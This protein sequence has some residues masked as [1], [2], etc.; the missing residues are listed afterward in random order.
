MKK[1]PFFT[2]GIPVYNTEK[3]IGECLDSILSQDFDDFEIVCVDDGSTD[4]SLQILNEYSAKDTRVKVLSRKNDGPSTAR[5]AILYNASGKYILFADSD[6]KLNTNALS[7]AYRELTLN[8]Y[9]DIME[10]GFVNIINGVKSIYQPSYPGDEYFS[11]LLSDDERAVKLCVEKKYI[12]YVPAKFICTDFLSSN[13]ITFNSRYRIGEDCDFIFQ[14]HRKTKNIIFSH[15]LTSIHYS[16]REGSL[17]SSPS[18]RSIYTNLCY[19]TDFYNDSKYM[20]L[21]PEY[22]KMLWDRFLVVIKEKRDYTLSILSGS[23]SKKDILNTVD[24]IE[25]FIKPYLKYLPSANG[26]NKIIFTLYKF[27]GIKF[28]INLLY[29]YLKFKGIITD[30]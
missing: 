6:D 21:R 7:D 1:Q 2:I 29:T 3:W 10:T 11:S 18:D 9:P 5:N 4:N 28:T 16:P 15:I 13:G 25:A 20:D 27:I 12:P 30:E 19:E 22:R 24:M 8:N 17:T 14:I 23:V 26:Y